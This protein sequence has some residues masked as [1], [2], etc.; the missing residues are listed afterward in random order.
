MRKEL[1]DNQEQL[2]ILK[3]DCQKACNAC[4]ILTSEKQSLEN[5][6]MQTSKELEDKNHQLAKSESNVSSLEEEIKQRE[7]K[8]QEL[9]QLHEKEKDDFNLQIQ[10]YQA[11]AKHYEETIA[12]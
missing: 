1:N 8:Y 4:N 6:L 7:Q 10:T 2:V 3:Q 12:R 9:L 5:D 11:A